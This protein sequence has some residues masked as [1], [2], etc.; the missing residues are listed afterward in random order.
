MPKKDF[1][2]YDRNQKDF[3]KKPLS[4]DFQKLIFPPESD[5]KKSEDHDPSVLPTS[6]LSMRKEVMSRYQV[7]DEVVY[8]DGKT[9][10]EVTGKV[11][12]VINDPPSD[13]AYMVQEPNEGFLIELEEAEILE[14]IGRKKTIITL[15]PKTG[16]WE[17]LPKG[18]TEKSLR[19]F[20]N[21]LGGKGEHKVTR[22]I[23]KMKDKIDNPGAFCA[24]LERRIESSNLENRKLAVEDKILTSSKKVA[25]VVK[26]GTELAFWMSVDGE[27]F[28]SDYVGDIELIEP[29]KEGL[30]KEVPLEEKVDLG[31]KI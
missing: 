13:P 5:V 18:W 19:S 10:E 2:E 27:D 14:K 29:V 7:G 23:E 3:A 12:E 9:Y 25:K 28:G 30:V 21:S 15:N 24:S 20:W 22:C 6:K 11:V 26:V 8:I 4:K 16:A 17:N 1:T 31:E